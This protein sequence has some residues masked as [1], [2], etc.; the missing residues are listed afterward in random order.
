[1]SILNAG[2]DLLGGGNVTFHKG[3]QFQQVIWMNGG[4]Q[5]A[6][7][8]YDY[9]SSTLNVANITGGAS[10][11]IDPSKNITFNGQVRC[12]AGYQTKPGVNGAYT[13][14]QF[15]FDWVGAMQGWMDT[16]NLGN[17]TFASDYRIKQN[18]APLP[19]MWERLK[20]LNPISYEHKD[21]TPTGAPTTKED[22]SALD[23]MFVADGK[24]RWGSS[25]T[26][27]RKR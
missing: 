10:I 17:V 8:Y 18:V 23:P 7:V 16:T 3:G 19:G 9:N 5:V 12:S 27:S 24:E 20:A 25:P 1:M 6:Q 13:A 11:N 21:Y 15:N 14:H 4:S 26:S 2:I 22:G